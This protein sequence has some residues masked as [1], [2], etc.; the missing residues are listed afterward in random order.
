MTSPAQDE[1]LDMELARDRFEASTDFTVAIE[2][3]FALLDPG[4]LEL[5]H[6]FDAIFA[7]CQDDELLAE[8]AAGELIDTEIEIRSGRG[9]SWADAVARQLERRRRL[10]DLASSHEVALGA[11]GTHPWASYLDQEIIDTPH[12]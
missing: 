10:F 6:A 1:S 9:E 3:E 7:D 4:S 5:T 12:Y 2:E 11:M 8:S